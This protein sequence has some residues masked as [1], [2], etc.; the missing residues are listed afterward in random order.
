MKIQ[1]AKCLPKEGIECPDF[2]PSEKNELSA[3]AGKSPLERIVYL[4][5]RYYLSLEHAKYIVMHINDKTGNCNRC[6][7]DNLI[8]EYANCPQCG[9]FNFNWK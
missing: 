4:R 2:S 8:G 5:E 1:C 9:A 6:S 3:S 7:F